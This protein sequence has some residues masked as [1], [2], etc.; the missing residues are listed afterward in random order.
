VKAAA[1]GYASTQRSIEIADAA[2]EHVLVLEP[3]QRVTLRIVDH[4][5]SQWTRMLARTCPR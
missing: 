5:A 4:E 1:T 2:N 3:G